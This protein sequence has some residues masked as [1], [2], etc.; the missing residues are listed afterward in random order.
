MNSPSAPQLT[1]LDSLRVDNPL[2]GLDYLLDTAAVATVRDVLPGPVITWALVAAD[3]VAD[4]VE[5]LRR[6]D[7]IVIREETR[8]VERLAC[9]A[10]VLTTVA[11]LRSGDPV[12]QAPDEML[13]QVRAAFHQGADLP[14][15]IRFVWSH[16]ARFQEKLL[17]AQRALAP[18]EDSGAQLQDLHARM[19]Q[20]LDAYISA[21]DVEFRHEQDR[22]QGGVPAQRRALL[23][24]VLA[25]EEHPHDP[26]TRLG[27]RLA[28]CYVFAWAGTPDA[29]MDEEQRERVRGFR[30]QVGQQLG[31]TGGFSQDFA[32]DDILWCLTFPPSPVWEG[33]NPLRGVRLPSGLRLAVG[34]VARGV[35]ELYRAL[36][37][38]AE[39][40]RISRHPA[41]PAT[42]RG[43]T[44]L[45]FHED[46]RVLSVLTRS[47]AELADF[48][49]RV[50]GEL[51]G[52]T[53]KNV[54]LRRTLLLYLLHGRSRKGAA[55][56]LH[57]SPN[58]VA[59]RVEQARDLIGDD[60]PE[61]SLEM[62]LALQ[63]LDILP[64]LTS[65]GS[66]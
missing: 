34:P 38:V 40:H 48:V 21:V 30:E 33:D 39:A 10:G 64:G 2:V 29:V 60:S 17:L 25:G 24:E 43:V 44:D 50:L 41:R 42:G 11:S 28:G 53:A 32:D 13:R 26:E 8:K 66:R 65:S 6:S 4:E 36:V 20:I 59:Y 12:E 5:D 23:E 56:V 14:S 27:I 52:N 7:S 15:I 57:I 61:T 54:D 49:G 47:E 37:G 18:A 3:Q 55:A 31:A 22:W 62:L 51:A 45:V 35:A 46:I 16:H 1:W 58:T 9:A 19:H 63:I